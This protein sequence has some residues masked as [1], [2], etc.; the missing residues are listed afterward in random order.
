MMKKITLLGLLI[1]GVLLS[2]AQDNSAVHTKCNGVSL[3]ILQTK[4]SATVKG[5]V[6]TA[7]DNDKVD[8]AIAVVYLRYKNSA[9]P[10]H[11]QADL[12][13]ENGEWS[14]QFVSLLKEK[15]LESAEIIV[16][17]YT[18][19]GNAQRCLI[20]DANNNDTEMAMVSLR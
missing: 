11:Q 8:R 15:G 5:T 7:I 10:Q 13:R 2:F 12:V 1:S 17:T 19:D 18:T 16:Y 14:G 6:T 3:D 4:R 9:F 20:P